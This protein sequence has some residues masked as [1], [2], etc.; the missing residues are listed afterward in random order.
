[1]MLLDFLYQLLIQVLTTCTSEAMVH[2][3]RKMMLQRDRRNRVRI[4]VR[5]RDGASRKPSFH[6]L[7]T[8]NRRKQ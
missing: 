4:S 2:R 7:P 5:A 8:R 6:K 1:M 3:A